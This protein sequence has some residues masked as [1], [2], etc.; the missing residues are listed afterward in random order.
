MPGILIS[1]FLLSQTGTSIP[2]GPVI[3]TIHMI[4]V[5]VPYTSEG[6]EA[7]ASYPD[8]IK[9]VK[10][11]LQDAGR[12]MQVYLSRKKRASDIE[13]KKETFRKYIPE[14]A[15]A[16]NRI[17]GKDAKEIKNKLNKELEDR[18]ESIEVK[19]EQY[20]D[21]ELK[22]KKKTEKEEIEEATE[23]LKEE[24]MEDNE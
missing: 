13:E 20:D 9:E 22:G 5:W 6:K 1:H 11:G 10:L 23:E 7:V 19:T 14:I 2:T 8:I 16:L 21:L 18:V 17:T 24:M 4:S 3:F 15:S 12:K